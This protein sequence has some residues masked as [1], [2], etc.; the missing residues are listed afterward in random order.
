MGLQNI[1]TY[2]KEYLKK[3]IGFILGIVKIYMLY[4][5]RGIDFCAPQK[6][7]PSVLSIPENTVTR[8]TKGGK[9]SKTLNYF[10]KKKKKH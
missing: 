7:L 3:E 10:Y 1:I 2:H 6:V 4:C 9:V 5:I 8:E